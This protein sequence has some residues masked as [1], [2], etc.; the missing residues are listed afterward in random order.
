[1]P[2]ACWI[3]CFVREAELHVLDGIK[4]CA[5]EG[6]RGASLLA[7]PRRGLDVRDD[8]R[9]SPRTMRAERRTTELIAND[10]GLARQPLAFAK[11]PRRVGRAR[12]DQMRR[13]QFASRAGHRIARIA[14]RRKVRMI[15]ALREPVA[16]LLQRIFHVHAV[17]TRV[18]D[19]VVVRVALTRVVRARTVVVPRIP[20]IAVWIAERIARPRVVGLADPE[21]PL[22][23][24]RKPSRRTGRVPGNVTNPLS[25]LGPRDV[26]PVVR[27]RAVD[28]AAGSVG[29]SNAERIACLPS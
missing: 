21:I 5:V 25:G 15:D 28:V 11:R 27:D 26:R 10:A 13:S 8:R 22:A 12:L 19:P 2:R 17:V 1:M 9:C 3:R 23:M 14:D 7:K 4:R 16:V 6:R 20:M 24:P 18:A 29:R